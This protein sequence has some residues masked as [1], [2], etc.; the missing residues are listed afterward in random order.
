MHYALHYNQ[1]A[2]QGVRLRDTGSEDMNKGREK[3]RRE[4]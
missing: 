3:R 1:D 4:R 2:F